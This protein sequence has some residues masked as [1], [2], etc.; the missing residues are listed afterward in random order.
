MAWLVMS[1]CGA[2]ARPEDCWGLDEEACA[3]ADDCGAA[4]GSSCA[5]PD[6]PMVF[7]GCHLANDVCL[8]LG[9]TCRPVGEPDGCVFISS[10]CASFPNGYC[11]DG[12]EE[13]ETFGECPNG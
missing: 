5:D 9:V 2:P 7:V 10:Q 8:D 12:W 1:A 11:P 4:H 6:G 13:C 3:A